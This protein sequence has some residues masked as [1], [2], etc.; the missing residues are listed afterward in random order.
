MIK[1]AGC[2]T[3]TSLKDCD[4]LILPGVGAFPQAMKALKKTSLDIGIKNF[5]NSGKPLIGICLGFQ[6]FSKKSCEFSPTKGL[7]LINAE[8]L[9]FKNSDFH[10][11]WNEIAFKGPLKNKFKENKYFFFNHSYYLNINDTNVIGLAST[12]SKKNFLLQV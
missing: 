3:K 10:I 5:Y 4:A 7:A 12:K 6:L 9:K 2:S 11:G 8:V 1:A